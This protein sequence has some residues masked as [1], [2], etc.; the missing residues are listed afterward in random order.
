MDDSTQLPDA[1]PNRAKRRVLAVSLVAAGLLG[2]GMLAGALPAGAQ[3]ATES[4]AT[5]ESPDT[6]ADDRRNCPDKADRGGAE[7]STA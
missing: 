3:T 7:A 4:P 1:P 2:G 5:P 6:D